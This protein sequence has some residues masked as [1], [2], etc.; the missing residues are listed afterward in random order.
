MNLVLVKAPKK[1]SWSK[2]W[3]TLGVDS[4]P[5]WEAWILIRDAKTE[6]EPILR[7]EIG[8]YKHF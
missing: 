4:Y 6:M 5:F 3:N 8:H 1:K 7:N 2:E